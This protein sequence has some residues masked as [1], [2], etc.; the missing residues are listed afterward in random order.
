MKFAYK[1]RGGPLLSW[2][3]PAA[4]LQSRGAD[5]RSL[6]EFWPTEQ[7][8]YNVRHIGGA[9]RSPREGTVRQYPYSRAFAGDDIPRPGSPEIIGA[10]ED[11]KPGAALVRL[12]DYMSDGNPLRTAA[13]IASAYHG[14]KRNDSIAAAAIWFVAASLLPYPT[15]GYAWYQ[16]FGKKK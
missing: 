3:G 16:G 15:I 7:R 6:G 1:R 9:V 8:S 5:A 12:G 13:V 11:P 14:Y 4:P 2:A 10:Y